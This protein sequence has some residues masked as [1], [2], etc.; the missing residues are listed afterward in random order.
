MAFLIDRK[1][2]SGTRWKV[3]WQDAR[4]GRGRS[5]RRESDCIGGDHV[6]AFVAAKWTPLQRAA[7]AK[8]AATQRAR[9]NLLV[10]YQD[11]EQ[12]CYQQ[13]MDAELQDVRVDFELP[14]TALV[15]QFKTQLKTQQRQGESKPPGSKAKKTVEAYKLALDH[16]T[17][18]LQSQNLGSMACGNLQSK[19]LADFCTAFSTSPSRATGR[20]V[21]PAT[22]NQVV[23]SLKAFLRSVGSE[24]SGVRYFKKPLIALLSAL[25]TVP[26]GS[27]KEPCHFNANFIQKFCLRALKLD[28]EELIV[29]DRTKR[30]TKKAE[31]F[32][33]ATHRTPIFPWLV[34]LL[35][36]G[37]R[38][39]E[40]AQLRWRDID[41]DRG[42][43]LLYS[44]KLT[45]R[46]LAKS[47]RLALTD[48]RW[49]ISPT[50]M[51]LLKA[52]SGG[53]KPDEFVLV[54]DPR[55][56][57]R[58]GPR[59]AWRRLAKGVEPKVTRYDLRANWVTWMIGQGHPQPIVALL[60]G[61]RPDVQSE[62]YLTLPVETTRAADL[63]S[64]MGITDIL[65][66]VL[67]A[68]GS[69]A[70]KT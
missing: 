11:L 56:K 27:A 53:K 58:A 10:A 51:L 57:T 61:H 34:M 69:G 6:E 29:V 47:R 13:A 50:L 22:F 15:E 36:T 24:S 68:A 48:S 4:K 64:A 14:F 41:F 70:K 54:G 35:L 33:M 37:A 32:E 45:R 67:E 46:D 60:A 28:E 19:Q 5:G 30:N 43:L 17:R 62:H 38:P 20:P 8:G 18:F 39:H 12:A 49:P 9:Q 59:R 31:Q 2:P 63:E 1:T 25:K 40:L 7:L 21:S 66:G 55:M 44:N 52:W 42:L 16:L 3:V 65:K 26:G 23:R